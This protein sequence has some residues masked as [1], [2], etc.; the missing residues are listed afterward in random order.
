M[1]SMILD[2]PVPPHSDHL[3]PPDNFGSLLY[4]QGVYEPT[5]LIELDPAE[6]TEYS[7]TSPPLT[8]P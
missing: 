4:E 1:G 3:D 2:L 6:R 7:M 5:E 8:C